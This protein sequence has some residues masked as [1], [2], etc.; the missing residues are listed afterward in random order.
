MKHKI[1][2]HYLL[3]VLIIADQLFLKQ[4]LLLSTQDN[5]SISNQAHRLLI[6]LL[7]PSISFASTSLEF[8]FA[9]I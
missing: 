4:G 8:E 9:L 2:F 3:L 7:P 6:I 1:K 5:I